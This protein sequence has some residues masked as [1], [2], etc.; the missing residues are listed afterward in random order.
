MGKTVAE[1]ERDLSSRELTEWAAYYQESPFE[2]EGVRGDMRQAITS[3]VVAGIMGGDSDPKKYMPKYGKQSQDLLSSN[4]KS[5]VS[6]MK[7]I[8]GS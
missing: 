6:K 7:S 4:V 8:Q 3:A 5:F 2:S 1:L